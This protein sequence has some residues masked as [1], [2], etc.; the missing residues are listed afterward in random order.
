[1]EK[2]ASPDPQVTGKLKYWRFLQKTLTFSS[3]RLLSGVLRKFC[4]PFGKLP[5]S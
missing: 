5:A 1:L 3:K 4:L 2:S